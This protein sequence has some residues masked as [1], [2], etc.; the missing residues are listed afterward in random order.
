MN[1][2]TQKIVL[3]SIEL[4]S[5]TKSLGLHL[6]CICILEGN[7]G[8]VQLFSKLFLAKEGPWILNEC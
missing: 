6:V 7:N 5:R 4:K 8:N 2:M 1:K 3:A